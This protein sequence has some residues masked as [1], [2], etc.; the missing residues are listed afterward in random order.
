MKIMNTLRLALGT[1]VVV[2]CVGCV[3]H[4]KPATA[5]FPGVQAPVLLGPVDRI[6]GGA[7]LE[8]TRVRG[9]SGEAVASLSQSTSGGYTTTTDIT[10]NAAIVV[11]A[12]KALADVANGDIRVSEI[13]ARAWGYISVVKTTVHVSG[14]VYE[15]GGAR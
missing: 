1:L 4:L 10:N 14:K 15:V 5:S 9:F 3:G 8:K 13:R 2:T 12:V 6:G 7:P 11:K